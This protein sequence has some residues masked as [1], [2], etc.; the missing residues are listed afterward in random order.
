[1][2]SA[3]NAQLVRLE[4]MSVE[5]RFHPITDKKALTVVNL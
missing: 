5:I 2:T 3:R 4:G 1:M